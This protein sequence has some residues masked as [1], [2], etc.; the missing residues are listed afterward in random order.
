MEII[1]K[2]VNYTIDKVNYQPKVIFNQLNITFSSSMIHG[3]I[4]KSGSGKTILLELIAAKR[5]PT[6]GE[7]H[8]TGDGKSNVSIGFLEEID[9][10][11]AGT[12]LD[13]I[14][15]S[16]L[17]YKPMSKQDIMAR[18][19]ASLKLVGLD[20]TYL[21][22]DW[23]DLSTGEKKKILLAITLFHNPK[24]LILD[25]PFRNLDIQSKNEFCKLFKML[26]NRYKKTIIVAT[27][28]IEALHKIVDQV[29]VLSN[30]KIVMS[31]DKYSVFSNTKELKKY[32]VAPPK[33]MVFS[34][35]VLE[36]KKIK[37]GY[38]DEINDVLKDIYRYAKW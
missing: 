14:E 26:K 23:T 12:V 20:N 30:G 18:I 38:R 21:N 7:I 5:K 15:S 17:L 25:D 1:T 35:R 8:I 33:C 4:G 24:I 13:K 31:G 2:D 9:E 6:S 10:G 34:N 28:D 3:I 37:I 11:I 22:N 16:I 27:N 36:K 32:G 19:S 29:Y